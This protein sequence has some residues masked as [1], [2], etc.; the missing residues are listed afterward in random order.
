ME[1]IFSIGWLHYL[2]MG[3]LVF[4]VVITWRGLVGGKDGERGLARRGVPTLARLE[5]WRLFLV[6]LTLTGLGAAW[7]WDLR[8]LLVLSLGVGFAELHETTHILKAWRWDGGKS[9]AS[10]PTSGS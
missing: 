9:R 3:V 1:D 7:F 8:W 6:G 10:S 4:G 5:G 2:G